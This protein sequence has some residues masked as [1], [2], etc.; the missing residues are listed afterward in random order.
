MSISPLRILRASEAA[1][2]PIPYYISLNYDG[3]FKIQHVRNPFPLKP[4]SFSSLATYLECPSCALDQRPRK[5][6]REPK[7]FTNLHQATLFGRG[8]PDPRLV[9]TL[10]HLIVN[11][12]HDPHGPLSKDQQEILLAYPD[13]LTSFL[14]DELQNTLQLAGKLK[15]AMFLDELGSHEAEYRAIVVTPMLRYQRELITSGSTVFSASERFQFKLLST[16][17]TF[18]GHSDWG[19][20][21]GIVGEFDQIRLRSIGDA[22]ASYQRPAIIEFKNGLGKKK[23]WDKLV[24]SLEEDDNVGVQTDELVEP[25]MVHA[26]QLMIYWMAFQTRW[27]VRDRLAPARGRDENIRMPLQ[28]ELDLILYNLQDGCQYQLVLSDMPAALLALT[29]CIFY[30]DWAMKSGYAWQAPEHD[31]KKTSLL[32]EIPKN[33]VF[34]GHEPIYAEECYALARTAFNTLKEMVSWKKLV[35]E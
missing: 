17:N 20:Y 13:M 19:G 2:Q 15:L 12:L 9:G 21:V 4:V 6:S 18:A 3:Y 8:R 26:L 28:Q 10:L 14:H 35:V 31:C 16:R 1:T 24:S 22:F 32:L 11:L 7:H 30:L 25:G 33:P 27:D 23:S 29:N 5:R 34:V